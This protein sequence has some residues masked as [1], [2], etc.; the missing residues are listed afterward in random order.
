VRTRIT[1]DLLWLPFVVA[2][3]VRFTGDRE[4]LSETRPFLVSEPLEPDEEERYGHYQQTSEAYSLYEHCLRALDRGDT[5]GRHGL[6]LIGAGDW[7]DGMNHV[8]NEGRG[9]SVWLGWFLYANMSDFADICDQQG[10]S[11]RAERYRTRGEELRQALEDNAWDGE[12]YIRAFYDDGAPLG[13]RDN[14]ECQI[15]SI[16]QSWAL[17]SAAGGPE[18]TR[19]AMAAVDLRL[20]SEDAALI[21]LF[22]PPFDETPRDPGYIKGYPPGIRENG[23][24]YTHAAIWAIWGYVELGQGDRAERLFRLINPIYHSHTPELVARYEVEPYVVAADVY[25]E[26]PHIGR[27][28]WTWYTGSGG[29]LYQLG[30]CAILGLRRQENEFIIEPCIPQDWSSY[31]MTVRHGET[32]YHIRVM[33]PDGVNSG[34]SRVELDGAEQSERTVPLLEDGQPHDVVVTLGQ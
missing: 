28:G 20:V 16:A 31:E 4:I 9:E 6:P 30:L 15:D 23:G 2:R 29:W 17:I 25:G 33:N 11:G 34:V 27:G 14:A 26:P 32:R 5:R 7:N 8:G 3:Y 10:D 12:W 19:Q 22:T 13:S 24:Q 1:D 21:R 18:R